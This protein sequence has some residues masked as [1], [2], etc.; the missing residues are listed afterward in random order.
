MMNAALPLRLAF[1]ASVA[2]LAVVLAAACSGN[3]T[4]SSGSSG[5]GTTGTATGTAGT[6]SGTTGTA[7]GTG[8]STV[9]FASTIVPVFQA[10]CSMNGNN[11]HGAPTVTTLAQMRPYLG[12]PAPDTVP[13]ATLTMIWSGLMVSSGEDP[14]MPLVS[15]GSDA[16]SYLMHKMDDTISSLDCSKG[17]DQGTCGLPMPYTATML[18]QS[19]RDAIRAWINAGA[20][21]N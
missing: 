3:S 19:T 2:A 12:P 4:G 14:T 6:A 18:P 10:N 20:P 1:S 9:S 15:P 21:N 8:G 16:N 7:S 13:A 5:G 17:D 11:C